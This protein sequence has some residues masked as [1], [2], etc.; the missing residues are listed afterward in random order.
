MPR[1]TGYKVKEETKKKIS[2]TRKRLG[3]KP[4]PYTR[5]PNV[6]IVCAI[7]NTSFEEAVAN[8]WLELN[9]PPNR[10]LAQLRKLNKN[11]T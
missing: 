2:A 10:A 6:K 7:C 3:L 9:P 4:A 1:P 8:L 5:N 11:E